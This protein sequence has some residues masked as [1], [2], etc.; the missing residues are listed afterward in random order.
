MSLIYKIRELI[1]WEHED[2][3]YTYARKI[4]DEVERLENYGTEAEIIEYLEACAE[5]RKYFL[6]PDDLTESEEYYTEKIHEST[7]EKYGV[8]DPIFDLAFGN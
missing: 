5:M 4:E 8:S 1:A 7:F 3:F 2:K 6:D